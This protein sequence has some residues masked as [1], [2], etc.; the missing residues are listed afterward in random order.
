MRLVGGGSGTVLTPTLG[1]GINSARDRILLTLPISHD[2]HLR[3]IRWRGW[4]RYDGNWRGGGG[5]RTGSGIIRPISRSPIR[6]F[7]SRPDSIGR[8]R[9]KDSLPIFVASRIFCACSF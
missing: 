5:G 8:P 4:C 3:E 7:G 2:G 1:G 6:R 9:S